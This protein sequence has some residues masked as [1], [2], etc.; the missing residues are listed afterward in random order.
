MERRN[1]ERDTCFPQGG[2]GRLP[3]EAIKSQANTSYRKTVPGRGKPSA[4]TPGQERVRCVPGT[5]LSR[6]WKSQQEPG[7]AGPVGRVHE[8]QSPLA[9][10]RGTEKEGP[11]RKHPSGFFGKRKFQSIRVE[12]DHLGHACSGL[13]K[14]ERC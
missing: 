11:S 6:G 3:K 2:Q 4:R 13:D 12:R 9:G 1:K 7:H 10:E 8:A 14:R 5:S